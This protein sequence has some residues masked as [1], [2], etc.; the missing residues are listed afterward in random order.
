[1]CT[2]PGIINEICFFEH[3]SSFIWKYKLN[4]RTLWSCE[5]SISTCIVLKLFIPP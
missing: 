4:N 1:M 5:Y 2:V 3:F